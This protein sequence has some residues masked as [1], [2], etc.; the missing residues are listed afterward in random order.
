V[1]LAEIL[2]NRFRG[3]I[4]LRGEAYL[5]AERVAITHVSEKTILGSVRDGAEYQ[6]QLSRAKGDLRLQCSCVDEAGRK[7]ACKHL[8]ATVLAADDAGY[9]SG[10]L[11]PGHIPP[12]VIGETPKQEYDFE[13][14]SDDEMLVPPGFAAAKRPVSEWEPAEF[15][16]PPRAGWEAQLDGVRSQLEEHLATAVGERTDRE[17]I[18]EIDRARTREAG[19]LV[20]Q[21]SQRQRRADGRWSSR[22]VL[23]I[24]P[25]RLDEIE[26]DGDRRVL[27]FLAGAKPDSASGNSRTG[28]GSGVHHRFQLPYELCLLVLPQ[29]CETGRVVFSSDGSGRS[30][31]IQWD[32]GEPWQFTLR[33]VRIDDET[34]WTLEGRLIRGENVLPVSAADFLLPGGI[35]ALDNRL[36]KLEDYDALEWLSLLDEG[37]TP[38]V[39]PDAEAETFVDRLL[40]MPVLPRLELPEHLRL[41]EVTAEP[42]PFLFVKTP[43]VGKRRRWRPDPVGDRAAR[44]GPLP[45]AEP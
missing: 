5:K 42:K 16:P 33:L 38:P 8:W 12:F 36:A 32:D 3:D 1:T 40:D 13:I 9:V 14:D 45:A 35:V 23:R 24:R 28:T 11:K 15:S 31:P 26:N 20:V 39:I 10:S 4:R 22:K 41:E 34:S 27:A 30:R 7:P 29:M 44:G 21:I 18:Y 25:D 37:D 43:P 2:E 17:V 6:T 19:Q